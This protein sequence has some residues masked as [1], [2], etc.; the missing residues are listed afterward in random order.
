[1]KVVSLLSQVVFVMM[2]VVLKVLEAS[3][4][5]GVLRSTSMTAPGTVSWTTTMAM[6]A[7]TTPAGMMGFLFAAS[8]I[9]NL[10]ILWTRF[11]G[12]RRL[13]NNT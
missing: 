13:K 1:M 6:C 9:D 4:T 5:F 7:G 2:L 10:S 3:L 12:V 8:G 11:A